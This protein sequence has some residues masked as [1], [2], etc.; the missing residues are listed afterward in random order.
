MSN[1]LLVLIDALNRTDP[2]WRA[3]DQAM[4]RTGGALRSLREGLRDWVIIGKGAID[5]LGRIRDSFSG[6]VGQA[7]QQANAEVRL[8]AALAQTTSNVRDQVQAMRDFADRRQQLT[9]FSDDVTLSLASLG[10]SF[11]ITGDTLMR[12]IEAVQDR[13]VA[14]GKDPEQ[15]MM[16]LGKFFQ[17][18]ANDLGRLGIAVDESLP[19]T[20]AFARVI[21][22][23]RTGVA[24][25]V[26]ELP[27]S[28]FAKLGNQIDEVRESL[29]FLIAS[30]GTFQAITRGIGALARSLSEALADPQRL[31]EWTQAFDRAVASVVSSVGKM[32]AGIVGGIGAVLGALETLLPPI[33]SF[34]GRF[35]KEYADQVDAA[36]QSVDRLTRSLSDLRAQ[37]KAGTAEYADNAHGLELWQRKLDQLQGRVDLSS[38]SFQALAESIRSGSQAWALE[39]QQGETLSSVLD[40]IFEKLTRLGK[41]RREEGPVDQDRAEMERMLAEQARELGQAYTGAFSLAAIE[42]FDREVGLHEAFKRLGSNLRDVFVGQMSDAAFDPIKQT[43]GNLAR[44]LAQPFNVVGRAIDAALSPITNLISAAVGHLASFLATLLGVQTTASA[45]GAAAMTTLTA[46][47]TGLGGAWGGAAIA[48]SIATLGQ[49][50]SIGGPAAIGAITAGAGITKA[51]FATPL[52]EGGLVMPRPGGVPAILAEAGEPEL[53]LPLSKAADFFRDAMGPAR[54]EVHVQID[55]VSLLPEDRDRALADLGREMER[56][57]QAVLRALPGSRHRRTI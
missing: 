35:D 11:G 34:F 4:T 51:L 47:A 17:G 41:V 40:S 3:L 22:Q 15:L 38:A 12:T 54:V 57:A 14:F 2:A 50:V 21:Q 53:A 49:A 55:R 23:L 46:T 42:S 19:R 48:A 36:Q 10:A 32:L 6:L 25:A 20:E 13:A 37:G 30:T 26:G 39:I 31:K 24:E 28:A 56:Q 44:S 33:T 5:V 16:A 1:T 18:T 9:T 8:A 52:A 7:Q 29:G 27:T 45:A 43:I